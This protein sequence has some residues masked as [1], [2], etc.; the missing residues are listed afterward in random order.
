MFFLPAHSQ[1]YYTQSLSR[2]GDFLC[3]HDNPDRNVKG[4]M[5]YE[6]TLTDGKLTLNEPGAQFEGKLTGDELIGQFIPG[7]GNPMELAL[8]KE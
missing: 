3:F 1:D 4:V 2:K 7:S 6:A 8:K 5:I